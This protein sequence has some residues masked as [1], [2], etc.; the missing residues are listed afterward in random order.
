MTVPGG[1]VC[2]GGLQ[3]WAHNFALENISKHRSYFVDTSEYFDLN[4]LNAFH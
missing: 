1:R 2:D 3:C 4:D